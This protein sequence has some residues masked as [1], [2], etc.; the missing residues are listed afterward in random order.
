MRFIIFTL[1]LGLLSGRAQA[2]TFMG[3]ADTSCSS[4]SRARTER[5]AALLGMTSWVGGYLSS[6][7]Y[8]M[9]ASSQLNG[10]AEIDLLGDVEAEDLLIWIDGYCTEKPNDQM[11]KAVNA[12]AILLIDRSVNRL[13]S[14]PN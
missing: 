1:V 14:N 5:G 7:A 10:G 12:L 4:W 11:Q 9:Y 6:Q 2:Q 13:I 8:D 3:Y